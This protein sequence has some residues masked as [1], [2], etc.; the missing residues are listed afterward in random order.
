VDKKITINQLQHY[1]SGINHKN[2]DIESMFY[3]LIEEVGE[4]SQSIRKNER[5]GSEKIIKNTVEE[6]LYDVMYYII[7]IANE[8]NIDLE[9][10]VLLKE[11]L[12][13]KKYKRKSFFDSN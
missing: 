4:L 8:M 5:M 2:N 13:S 1:I 11:D 10:C 9:E 3:K 7:R 12:N 6:E